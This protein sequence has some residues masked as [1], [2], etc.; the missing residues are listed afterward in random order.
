MDQGRVLRK[1]SVEVEIEAPSS[2]VFDIIHDYKRRLEWDSLLSEAK[3]LDP[4]TQAAVGVSTRCVGKW[5]SCWMVMDTRYVSFDRGR[6]AAVT[7]VNRPWL[8]ESFHATIR[9]ETIN[10]T[11]S[12]VIYIYAF[13]CRPKWLAWVWEPMVNRLL[14]RETHRRLASLRCYVEASVVCV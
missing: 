6:V 8:F 5:T 3:V 9:H 12:R 11:R 14:K 4:A 10:D 7:L 1:Q 2:L 13:A